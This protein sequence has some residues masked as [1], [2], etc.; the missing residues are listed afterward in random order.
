MGHLHPISYPF[1]LRYKEDIER[2]S[3]PAAVSGTITSPWR[4]VMIGPDLN[5]LVNCDVVPNLCPP[6]DE[7]LFP[8]GIDTDWIK[9]GRA[10]WQYLDGRENTLEQMKNFC[11]MAGELGFEYKVIEGFWQRWSDAE[12][13][14]LVEY[15]RQHNVG[16]WLWKHTREIRDP[17]VRHE[18]L[19]RC[20]GLGAA[21]VKPDFFDHE[22]KEIIDF[23][24]TLLRE[25]A[26]LGLLVNFHG[27]NKPTGESRTWPNELTR[28]AVRGMEYRSDERARHNTTLPYTRL[29]AG[30]ADYTPVHF[31]E[32][33]ADTS[34][35]HQ[36]ASAALLCTNGTS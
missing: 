28:E 3:K 17:Q 16:I 13:R 1:E 2:V 19:Q 35:A 29:L 31:G 23:Y 21:G 11:R 25:T 7:T 26:E 24:H 34:W 18:F 14:E 33:L 9:P 15:G 27:S 12:V 5:A 20:H 32:P 6:P 4:V 8:K 36:I 22:A 30:H 10:V